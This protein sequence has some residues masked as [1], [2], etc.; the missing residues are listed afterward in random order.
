[1][2]FAKYLLLA[3]LAVSLSVPAA[4]RKKK[5]V[6]KAEAPV[7]AKVDTV[8]R[9]VFSY[10]MGVANTEGLKN[11]LAQ[12]MNVDTTHMADFVRGFVE[13]FD[14]K[15]TN[16]QL[17]AY[18][19]GLQLGRQVYD[20]LVPGV[21]E[22]ATGDRTHEAMNL[23]EFKRGFLEAIEGRASMRG[24]SA[25]AIANKQMAY[26]HAQLMEQKYGANRTEGEAF[27]KQN[28]KN[29]SVKTLPSGV[30]YKVLKEGTG[31]LPKTTDK[32]KVNYEGSLI[33]GTVFDSS[34]KRGRPATF[35]VN[36]VIKGWGEAL[37]HMPVG[38]TWMVYIPQELGYGEREAGNI[39]PFSTLIFKIELLEIEA[40]AQPATKK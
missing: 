15:G 3:G 38:S 10:A 11:Y 29:D 39:P 21:N 14:A 32:V 12:R 6:K 17:N 5:T 40:P 4:A 1:M 34:Y 9:D 7:E 18:A 20:G 8:S 36:Q 13:Q 35:G 19:A 31:A 16:A 27:L 26:Y 2:K 30:Q 22:Q 25:G 24:D 23:Q 28:A 37:T 33:N